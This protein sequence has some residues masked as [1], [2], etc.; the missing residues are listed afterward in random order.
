[1]YVILIFQFF[2]CFALEIIMYTG[3]KIIWIFELLDLILKNVVLIKKSI[4]IIIYHIPLYI[5]KGIIYTFAFKIFIKFYLF[6]L[7]FS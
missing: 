4:Y 1:M 7:I 5:Y 2:W 3:N 6:S